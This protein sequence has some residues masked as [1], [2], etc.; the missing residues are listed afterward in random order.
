[1]MM[2][3][4]PENFLRDIF[5][6]SNGLVSTFV[7]RKSLSSMQ[8]RGVLTPTLCASMN[9]QRI[10]NRDYGLNIDTPLVH[11]YIPIEEKCL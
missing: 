6:K 11:T 9:V 7:S 8:G 10:I 1:M 5:F 2:F 4:W 3:L